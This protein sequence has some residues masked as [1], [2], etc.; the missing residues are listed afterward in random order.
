V[1]APALEGGAR[2]RYA[3][4]GYHGDETRVK[5]LIAGVIRAFAGWSVEDYA[6][7]AAIVA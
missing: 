3:W 5:L 2:T 1:G 6:D 7:A 4:L